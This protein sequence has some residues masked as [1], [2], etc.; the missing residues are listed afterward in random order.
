MRW[1]DSKKENLRSLGWAT[2]SSLVAIKEDSDLDLNGLRQLLQ[3]VEM[4]IHQEPNHVRSAMNAFVIA[5]G[6]YVKSLT[7][8]AEQTGQKIG[9]VR[10]DVGATACKV[11]YAPEAIQKAQKRGSIGKKRKT[12]KC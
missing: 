8:L 3:R 6:T 5:V 9:R 10:V 7:K 12:A 11:P 4:T 1:I 2:L